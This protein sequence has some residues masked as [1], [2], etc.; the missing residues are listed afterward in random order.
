MPLSAHHEIKHEVSEM[1]PSFKK[2]YM[3]LILLLLFCPL[4]NRPSD[5]FAAKKLGSILLA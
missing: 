5:S 4:F 2:A 1:F 3:F